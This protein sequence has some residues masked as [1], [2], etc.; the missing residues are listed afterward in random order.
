MIEASDLGRLTVSPYELMR[1]IL[2]P[3]LLVLLAIY[4][5]I[6]PSI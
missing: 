2:Q 1:I 6:K 4:N 5:H 3:V